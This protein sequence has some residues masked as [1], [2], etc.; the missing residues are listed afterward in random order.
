MAELEQ[1]KGIYLGDRGEAF[2]TLIISVLKKGELKD[3]HIDA[4]TTPKAMEKY[5]DAFTSEGIDADY[6][7]EVYEQLGDLTGNKIIVWYI[8]KRFP[9]LKRS[10]GVKVA[11][12]VRINYGAKNSFYKIAEDLGFWPYI[13]ATRELRQRKK[14]SL[15]EDV[16]EA[17]LGVTEE[18]LDDTFCIGVGYAC[19]YKI[20]KAI[21]DEMDISLRYED[22]YDAKTRLKELFD[23]NIND[24][25]PLYYEDTKT[26]LLTHATAYRLSGAVY[27]IRENGTVNMKKIVPKD[28]AVPIKKVII[29]RGSA[30]LKADAEQAAAEQALQTLAD[31][32]F[33]KLA[34]EIYT[35]FI[36]N[37]VDDKK[38]ATR[39]TVI[40]DIGGD[41][42]NINE[43]FATRGKSKYQA[44]YTSTVL[45]KYCRERNREAI[46][47]ALKLGADPNVE[48]FDGLSS[49]D[50]LLIG[51]IEPK[52]VAKVMKNM[53]KR[54]KK[55][56]IQRNVYEVYYKKYMDENEWFG[57]QLDRL[58]IID[59]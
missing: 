56:N 49:L 32:G 57:E 35:Q 25:G 9:Q 31:Q 47:I 19:V 40:R 6:N 15:L 51:H 41:L 21:F 46:K 17:F 8:Y 45:A 12:R 1:I 33:V 18:V 3:K 5:G 52:F 4:L 54:T 26:D 10:K 16:F 53:L 50:L 43:Q 24:L 30:A 55:L 23:R 42:A 59:E 28:R 58:N 14:K 37:T 7:Y 36:D 2:K 38:M 34:P 27:E 11:A 44:K 39:D 13:S 22:L 48:D 29:G 20:V